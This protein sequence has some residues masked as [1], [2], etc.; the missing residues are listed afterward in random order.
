MHLI[1]FKKIRNSV[2]L[3]CYVRETE[4][5]MVVLSVVLCY[6]HPKQHFYTHK[7]I[8]CHRLRNRVFLLL[9][10]VV[11]NPLHMNIWENRLFSEG[12]CYGNQRIWHIMLYIKLKV[13]LSPFQICKA[14]KPKWSGSQDMTSGMEVLLAKFKSATLKISPKI[15]HFFNFE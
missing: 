11:P 3:S 8:L 1:D 6:T 12:C 5:F 14:F 2:I 7:K 15:T 9:A 10:C 4:D 13:Y